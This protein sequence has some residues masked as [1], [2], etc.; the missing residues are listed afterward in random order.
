MVTI[1]FFRSLKRVIDI[2]YSLKYVCARFK[3]LGIKNV[4]VL[5]KCEFTQQKIES[6]RHT[7]ALA[8][9]TI[10]FGQFTCLFTL[11]LCNFEVNP[12]H[13]IVSSINTSVYIFKTIKALVFC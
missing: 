7:F 11:L 10:I 13:S 2:G 1:Y 6:Y 5:V 9:G 4:S 12:I 3:N 8:P